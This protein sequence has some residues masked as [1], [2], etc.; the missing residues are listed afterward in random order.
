[1]VALDR[2]KTSQLDSIVLSLEAAK[3]E[4]AAMTSLTVESSKSNLNSKTTS[5]KS[6]LFAAGGNGTHVENKS[7]TKNDGKQETTKNNSE[8]TVSNGSSHV[9]TAKSIQSSGNEIVSKRR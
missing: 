2:E 6:N 3:E 5:P 8:S 4:L 9:T 7:I 1:M